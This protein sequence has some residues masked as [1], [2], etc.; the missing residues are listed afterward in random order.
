MHNLKSDRQ[1][2]KKT[3][4]KIILGH[5]YQLL[6]KNKNNFKIIKYQL[7]INFAI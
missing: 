6:K 5:F 4:I 1:I 3:F 7:Q 2:T